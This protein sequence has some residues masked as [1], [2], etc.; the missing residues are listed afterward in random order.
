MMKART[1]ICLAAEATRQMDDLLMPA[2]H[3]LS[4]AIRGGNGAGIYHDLS[5]VRT[6]LAQAAR[7]IARAQEIAANTTWPSNEDYD[8]C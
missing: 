1:K 6:A 3:E 8:R 4:G 7:A 5:R 2:L